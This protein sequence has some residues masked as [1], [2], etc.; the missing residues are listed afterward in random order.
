MAARNFRG[1]TTGLPGILGRMS[2]T[3]KKLY[4]AIFLVILV[5]IIGS[6][7]YE[8]V[9]GWDTVTA[10][11][12]MS[13]TMTTVGYGDVAPKT[14][15]GRILTIIFVW[16]GVSLGLYL[17]YTISEFREKEVDERLKNFMGSIE[18]HGR[19]IRIR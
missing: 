15:L 8:H 7:A 1:E 2:D 5:F 9:E 19:K 13:A 16:V 4:F 17:I 18:E 10:V 12:F 11:Y 3:R 14:E 6:I